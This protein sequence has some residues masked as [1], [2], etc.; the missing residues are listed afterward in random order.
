[1]CEPQS[2]LPSLSIPS[3]LLLAA[4]AATW[5]VTC[6]G[7][8]PVHPPGLS[9]PA[10][11]RDVTGWGVLSPPLSLHLPSDSVHGGALRLLGHSASRAL[12][13]RAGFRDV[14]LS[15]PQFPHPRYGAGDSILI[16]GLLGESRDNASRVLKTLPRAK[17][18]QA[19][20][21]AVSTSTVIIP[22][23]LSC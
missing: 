15:L 16:T 3:R 20:V 17:G 9:R 10:G 21:A 5:P 2:P 8:S 22:W 12:G 18:A 1:M 6:D 13:F 23:W 4:P 19:T 7:W 11:C 14:H